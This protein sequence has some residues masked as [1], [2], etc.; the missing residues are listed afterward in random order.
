MKNKEIY[1]KEIEKLFEAKDLFHKELANIPFDE[2]IK[3]LVSLQKTANSI[4][5]RPGKIWEIS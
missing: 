3:I 2:K 1:T 5:R 4:Q